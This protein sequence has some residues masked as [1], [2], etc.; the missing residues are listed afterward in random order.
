MSKIRLRDNETCV[1]TFTHVNGKPAKLVVKRNPLTKQWIQV[2]TIGEDRSAYAG[3]K[4][5]A[6]KLINQIVKKSTE[7]S[8]PCLVE[9]GKGEQ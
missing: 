5:E 6:V 2:H 9:I 4:T 7:K 8:L 3:D 1:V